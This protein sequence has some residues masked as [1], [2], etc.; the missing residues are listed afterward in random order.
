MA[1]F[2]KTE[3]GKITKFVDTGTAK[4][5]SIV[6][7]LNSA[8]RPKNNYKIVGIN[9]IPNYIT[10]EED[11]SIQL[12]FEEYHKTIGFQAVCLDSGEL[13]QQIDHLLRDY[14]QE[15]PDYKLWMQVSDIGLKITDGTNVF[16]MFLCLQEK[17]LIGTKVINIKKKS[18]PIKKKIQRKTFEAIKKSCP[19]LWEHIISNTKSFFDNTT[20]KF[21]IENDMCVVSASEKQYHIGNFSTLGYVNANKALKRLKTG[22]ELEPLLTLL[23]RYVSQN[24]E[25]QNNLAFAEYNEQRGWKSIYYIHK[26][27]VID[28]IPIATT[29]PEM[30]DFAGKYTRLFNLWIKN[31]KAYNKH[32]TQVNRKFT[33]K[34]QDLASDTVADAS[35]STA[36]FAKIKFGKMFLYAIGVIVLGYC[37]FT[38]FNS[39][40]KQEMY[41]DVQILKRIKIFKKTEKSPNKQN[42]Y[43]TILNYNKLDSAKLTEE[44]LDRINNIVLLSLNEKDVMAVF[45]K[46]VIELEDELKKN[47]TLHL[48]KYNTFVTFFNNLKIDSGVF[49]AEARD[50][51]SYIKDILDGYNK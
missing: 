33:E 38:L 15:N 14:L 4:F 1:N 27:T 17:N 8:E 48:G 28:Q 40:V 9:G 11:D 10:I 49:N 25:F 24:K 41:S 37:S 51:I 34:M 3:T 26:G 22:L 5:K 32:V 20:Y 2:A 50:D 21:D 13:T 12:S 42:I 6:S 18:K 45:K 23:M 47:K 46:S 39:H 44:Q 16:D 19:I 7:D 31:G 35:K 30:E 36:Q 43:F 29:L